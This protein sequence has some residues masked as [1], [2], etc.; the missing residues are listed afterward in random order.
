MKKALSVVFVILFV[1]MS[2]GA[3]GTSSMES[4]HITHVAQDGE[5][6]SIFFDVTS[7]KDEPVRGAAY[8]DVTVS[9]D[10][11]AQQNIL[12]EQLDESSRGCRYLFVVDTSAGTFDG[13]TKWLRKA[14]ENWIDNM[15]ISDAAAIISFGSEIK[16]HNDGYIKNKPELYKIIEELKL[17]GSQSCL[18]DALDTA[19]TFAAQQDAALPVKSVIVLISDGKNLFKNTKATEEQLLEKARDAQIPIYVAGYEVSSNKGALDWLAGIT[20]VS[21]GMLKRIKADDLVSTCQYFY[22]RIQYSY[23]STVTLAS[24]TPVEKEAQL[25]LELNYNGFVVSATAPVT[26]NDFKPLGLGATDEYESNE[27][28]LVEGPRATPVSTALPASVSNESDSPA[29]ARPAVIIIAASVL[30]LIAAGLLLGAR[31][32]KKR[33]IGDASISQGEVKASPLPKQQKQQESMRANEHSEEKPVQ[34]KPKVFVQSEMPAVEKETAHLQNQQKLHGNDATGSTETKENV[35]ES[36]PESQAATALLSTHSQA[37][38]DSTLA[39]DDNETCLLTGTMP[40]KPQYVIRLSNAKLPEQVFTAGLSEEQPVSIGR[41][42]DNRIII[43]DST[44]SHQHC[45]ITVE[46]ADVSIRDQHSLNKTWLFH[47][48]IKKQVG[49]EVPERLCD[50]DELIVGN[51]RLLAEITKK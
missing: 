45:L 3:V 43:P 29:A 15:D 49:S 19:L 51:T 17:N 6:L 22:E 36:V 5:K 21:H 23:I 26:L 42:A 34:A 11:I 16:E 35:K 20:D 40:K 38:A 48:N 41:A 24:D 4:A 30:L 9:I 47:A 1:S 27:E 39:L 7:S 50:G 32:R 8:C 44:I 18:N 12:T 2:I 14:L 10:S 13:K 46:N 25:V 37:V 28:I 31:I 33:R